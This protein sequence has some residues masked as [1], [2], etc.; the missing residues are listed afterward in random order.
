MRKSK[1]RQVGLAVV[2]KPLGA[3]ILPPNG[4]GGAEPCLTLDRF[5]AVHTVFLPRQKYSLSLLIPV[6]GY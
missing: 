6:Q 4:L 2:L 1:N 3:F 5:L